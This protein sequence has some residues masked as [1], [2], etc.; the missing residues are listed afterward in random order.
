MRQHLV[1]DVGHY[2]PGLVIW[3]SGTPTRNALGAMASLL[4]SAGDENVADLILKLAHHGEGE[5]PP[6]TMLVV[7]IKT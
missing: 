3:A 4:L 5:V 2:V 1:N 7:G 6:S